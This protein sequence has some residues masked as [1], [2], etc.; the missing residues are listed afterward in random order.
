MSVTRLAGS[1]RALL[2]AWRHLAYLPENCRPAH[3][4]ASASKEES[5]SAWLSQKQH[6]SFN[7][8]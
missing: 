2:N 7:K 1:H 8:K 3:M 6:K 4:D 5:I